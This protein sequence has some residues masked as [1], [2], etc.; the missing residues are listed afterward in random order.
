MSSIALDNATHAHGGSTLEESAGDNGIGAGNGVATSGDGEDA[1]MDSL[2]DLGDASLDA[3]L[4]A[5]ISDILAALAN[6]DTGLLGRDNGAE[7]ELGL[8]VLLIRL[9]GGLA[10]GAEAVLHLEVVHRV[11]E[12]VGAVGG[13][14]ILGRHVGWVVARDDVGRKRNSRR[15]NSK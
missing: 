3:G 12:V 13:E 10:V 5:E 8:G 9:R 4:V 6:N 15:G 7:G 14:D 11:H 2:D 1:V